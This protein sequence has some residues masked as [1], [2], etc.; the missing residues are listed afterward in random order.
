MGWC[1]SKESFLN[2]M[3]PTRLQVEMVPRRWSVTN[4]VSDTKEQS[5]RRDTHLLFGGIL[6][7]HSAPAGRRKLVSKD[8]VSEKLMHMTQQQHP[9]ASSAASEWDRAEQSGPGRGL[10]Q[11]YERTL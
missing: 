1:Q 7:R 8:V 10:D 11:H 5:R 3:Q 2:K 4:E 6:W 9:I